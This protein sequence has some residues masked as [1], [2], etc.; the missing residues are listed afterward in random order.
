LTRAFLNSGSKSVVSSLWN[1]NEKAGMQIFNSFRANLN[2]SQTKSKALQNA[3]ITYLETH[4]NT[5][6]SSP[7]YW[8]AIVLTGNTDILLTPVNYWKLLGLSLA[9][10]AIF[11]LY[12]K[13]RKR[14]RN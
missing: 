7:Y 6:Q 8:G 10:I 5:S 13:L 9:G 3:K 14:N 2:Q 4:K 12:F 11:L 1:V